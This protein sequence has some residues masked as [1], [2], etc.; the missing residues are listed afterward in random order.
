MIL[1]TRI[2]WNGVNVRLVGFGFRKF[3]NVKIMDAGLKSIKARL[4]QGI[5]EDDGPTEKLTK[6]YARFKAKRTGRRAIRDMKLT[7]SL[8]GGLKT[9]YADDRHA[10][11][12]A[13]QGKGARQDRQKA[14]VHRK[15]L[16]FSDNDQKNMGIV[17][18]SLFREGVRQISGGLRPT[19]FATGGAAGREQIRTRRTF[20]GR[21]AA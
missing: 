11:A 2:K 9:R 1:D 7:G 18:A 14:R 4:A 10:V 3:H 12:D 19:R 8:L 21:A 17:A 13:G 15:L 5:G 20:F 6:R 16:L